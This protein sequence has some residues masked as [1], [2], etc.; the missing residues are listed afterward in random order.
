[1]KTVLA[2]VCSFTALATAFLSLSLIVLRPPRASYQEWFLMAALFMAQS[3]LTLVAISG[4]FSGTWIRWLL[5]VGG[6]A[7]IWVGASWAHATVSG[8][9]FEG[10]ALVLGSALV[11][12]GVLT[13]LRFLNLQQLRSLARRC[14]PTMANKFFLPLFLALIGLMVQFFGPTPFTMLVVD[15]Q[16]GVGVPLLRVTN[17]DG[18][19]RHLFTSTRSATP[20]RVRPF[21]AAPRPT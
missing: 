1:M 6:V 16:T 21:H 3:V 4:A 15:G 8:P 20:A 11:V 5:L 14:H 17:A 2:V 19:V 10:Y 12:Q 18:M 7:I 9:H 13:L